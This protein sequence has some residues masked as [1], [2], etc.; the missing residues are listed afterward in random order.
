MRTMNVIMFVVDSLR[1]DRLSCYGYGENKTPNIDRLADEGVIYREAYSMGVNTKPALPYLLPDRL[2]DSFKRRGYHTGLIHSNIHVF[3]HG[4]NFDTSI[5]VGNKRKPTGRFK[6]L[7]YLWRFFSRSE[8][9]AHEGAET[10]NSL[11]LELLRRESAPVFLVLWYMDV[12]FPYCP[13]G[14]DLTERFRAYLL[15]RKMRRACLERDFSAMNEDDVEDLSRLYDR[16]VSY[17]D[18]VVGD[19]IGGLDEE[20][21]YIFTADHGEEFYEDGGLGHPPYKDLPVLRR[22]PLIFNAPFLELT[23]I[24]EPFYFDSLAD[25]ILDLTVS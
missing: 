14:L 16:G 8:Y 10:I 12:H 13:P 17:M 1:A 20:T 2:I 6:R 21:F 23:V 19:L 22:V 3:L 9:Y 25:R 15:S 11:A 7:Y 5:D 18:R 4:D 24:E